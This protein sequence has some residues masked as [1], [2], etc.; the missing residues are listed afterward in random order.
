MNVRIRPLKEQDA[1]T[2]VKWRNDPEVFK[3]TGNIYNHEITIDNELEWIRKV[4]ANPTDYRCA[5]LVDEV[6]VG[7]IYLTDIKEGTAHFHIF[8]GD[9][10]YWG[11]GVAKRASLLILEYA[12]NVL[13]IKEVLLRVR[14]VNT[15]AYNL[16]LRLGFKD[17]KVDGIWTLMKLS[18]L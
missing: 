15:S 9:K 7:N 18:N 5:I 14:N 17:V 11:K 13:N 16:Y 2:S 6:Y 12:F 8:I 3:F 4:T 1:Y 10:S